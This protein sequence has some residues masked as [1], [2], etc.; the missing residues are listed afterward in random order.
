MDSNKILSN[1][2]KYLESIFIMNKHSLWFDITATLIVG[3]I[4]LLIIKKK[5][6]KSQPNELL[7]KAKK[8]PVNMDN[9]MLSINNSKMLY[10]ELSKKC[11]P[12]NFV[13]TDKYIIAE[14]IFKEISAY[15]R[16]FTAL[17]NIKGRAEVSLGVRFK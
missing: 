12:D 1:I 10:K 8:N 15:K 6:V 5:R 13:N 17:Q 3:I 4:I 11:H 16:D 7:Q 9:L 2:S 14:E